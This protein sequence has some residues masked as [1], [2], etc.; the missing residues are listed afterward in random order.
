MER[1]NQTL[2]LMNFKLLPFLNI[3]MESI[4]TQ[5]MLMKAEVSEEDKIKP[6][7]ALRNN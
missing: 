4:R 1:L 2:L 6:D 5:G 7:C 3:L